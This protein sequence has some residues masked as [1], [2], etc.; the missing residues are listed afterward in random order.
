MHENGGWL[1]PS[2]S[3]VPS[4][5]SQR[6]EIKECLPAPPGV[7]TRAVPDESEFEIISPLRRRTLTDCVIS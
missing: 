5:G 4:A 6:N 7:V 3:H 2:D 1:L